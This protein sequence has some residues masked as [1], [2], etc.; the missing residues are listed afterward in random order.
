MGTM[1]APG[2]GVGVGVGEIVGVGVGVGEGL[3]FT[4]RRGEIT[5]PAMINSSTKM[6]ASSADRFGGEQRYRTP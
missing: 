1:A 2:V 3:S 6:E 4:I 5:Q